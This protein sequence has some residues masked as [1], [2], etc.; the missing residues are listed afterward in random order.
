M[1]QSESFPFSHRLVVAS[2]RVLWINL[3]IHAE[4]MWE[5]HVRIS[6]VCFTNNYSE[7]NEKEAKKKL[8]SNEK[9][10]THR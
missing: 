10:N 5:F 1:F 4:K 7:Y 6:S 9:R 3:H 8:S 2:Q